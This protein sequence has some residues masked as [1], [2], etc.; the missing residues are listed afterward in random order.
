MAVSGALVVQEHVPRH[1]GEADLLR[2]GGGDGLGAGAA[3]DEKFVS[4]LQV[5][6]QPGHGLGLGGHA[7]AHV[8]VDPA[9]IRHGSERG[10][11]ALAQFFDGQL[12][13]PG[14]RPGGRVHGHVQ[15]D[16]FAGTMGFAGEFGGVGRVRH[17]RGG[18][19]AGEGQYP[20]IPG[21]VLPQVVD[22]QAQVGLVRWSG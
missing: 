21:Q 13:M 4:L 16:Q 9:G 5:R 1:A 17:D 20:A 3:V 2:L 14:E 7:A 19:R 18:D 22:D 8:V 12:R 6:H 15:H 10:V 11:E